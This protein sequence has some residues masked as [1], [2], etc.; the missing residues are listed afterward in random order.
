M[1]EWRPRDQARLR[2]DAQRDTVGSIT[3]L[4]FGSRYERYTCMKPSSSTE[5]SFSQLLN[6]TTLFFILVVRLTRNTA[7][8]V[9]VSKHTSKNCN[10]YRFFGEHILQI[11]D[12]C[13][14]WYIGRGMS[15][16][17]IRGSH[18]D[19]L[20]ACSRMVWFSISLPSR[21][22]TDSIGET[23]FSLICTSGFCH[24][25]V[26]VRPLCL[27]STW[28]RWRLNWET[29]SFMAV[30]F[31]SDGLHVVW[32]LIFFVIIQKVNSFELTIFFVYV[33]F[34]FL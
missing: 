2:A 31:C 18:Y 12:R 24:N 33:F 15:N 22:C 5:Y 30:E 19:W 4:L 7:L 6:F 23:G 3:H 32:C 21:C 29:V 34:L 10:C 26:C 11:L 27:R 9:C 28:Q 8:N 16:V 17:S 14:M 20:S 13:R 1:R 25:L